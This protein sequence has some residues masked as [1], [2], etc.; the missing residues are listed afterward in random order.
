MESQVP[1]VQEWQRETDDQKLAIVGPAS[2]IALGSGLSRLLGLAREAVTADLFGAT[3]LVSAYRV[4]SVVPTMLHDLLVGGMVSSALVPVFSEYAE[5]DQVQLWRVASLV[6]SLAV[7]ILGMLTLLAEFAAPLITWLLSGGFPSSL[8][9]ETTRLMRITIPAVLF[10]S[11]SSILSGVL[12]AQRR[13]VFPAFTTAIFNAAIV[14]ISLSTAARWGIRSMAVGLLGGAMLQV[15]LQIPGLR[16]MRFVPS[17]DLRDPGLHRILRLALPVFG[18]LVVSQMAVGIDRHLASGTAEQA[19]AWMQYATTLIQFPLGMVAAA[20]SLAVLPSLSRCALALRDTES[21]LEQRARFAFRSTLDRALRLVL[22]LIIPATMGLFLLAHPV[23]RLLFEHGDFSA[24]DTIQTARALRV[25]LIGLT[26]AAIDQPLIFAFYAQ[27]DT[28]TPAAVG[29]VGVLIYLAVALPLLRPLGMMALVFANSM[30]WIG[31]TL[32][33]MCLLRRR[34]G[35]F[36][37]QGLGSTAVQALLSALFM[38]VAIMGGRW[39][40]EGLGGTATRLGQLLTV[41]VSA[42]LGILFYIGGLAALGAE[43]WQ[44]AWRWLTDTE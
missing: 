26:F 43:E 16:P 44:L 33:M 4:A 22:L 1:D 32:I 12:Y 21:P 23:V 7:A 37:R 27:Q 25:Y 35:G 6:I 3:G 2:I 30:Q 9:T 38:T 13:F 18:G 39:Q 29:V 34:I 15:A 24:L 8:L 42:G 36:T 28:S 31:H 5:R 40:V 17:I 19:I 41:I 20:I 11:L 10:L 14:L